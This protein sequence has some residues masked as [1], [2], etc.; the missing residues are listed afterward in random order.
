MGKYMTMTY[1]DRRIKTKLD[2]MDREQ[3]ID[4]YND[5]FS[6]DYTI[7]DVDWNE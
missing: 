2:S 5:L 6:T 1:M 7:D 4:L 3:S